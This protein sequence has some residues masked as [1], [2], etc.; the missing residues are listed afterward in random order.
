MKDLVSIGQF[1][2]KHSLQNK[3]SFICMNELTRFEA[4]A[5]LVDGFT[6]ESSSA[7]PKAL[8]FPYLRLPFHACFWCA[9]T[10]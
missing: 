7:E 4:Q 3:V 2:N 9:E 8:A 10:S 5:Q 6:V 1:L